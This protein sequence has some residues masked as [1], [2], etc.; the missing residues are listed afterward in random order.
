MFTLPEVPEA[1]GAPPLPAALT[2]VAG[3]TKWHDVVEVVTFTV[4][5]S[6]S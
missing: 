1:E 2:L 6:V 4:I 5:D 3:N